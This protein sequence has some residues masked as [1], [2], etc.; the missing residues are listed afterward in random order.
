MN[1]KFREIVKTMDDQ[2]V[3]ITSHRILLAEFFASTEGYSAP[4]EIY[5]FMSYLHPGLSYDTVYRNLRLFVSIGLLEECFLARV[6]HFI[7]K[8]E[9]ENN[10]TFICDTCNELYLLKSVPIIH[11]EVPES[12]TINSKKIE[13]HGI[14]SACSRT[15]A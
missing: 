15:G 11:I 9:L 12:Y 5:S 1:A 3:R 14:C 8:S 2:G 6:S 4:N 13:I 10:I 7:L